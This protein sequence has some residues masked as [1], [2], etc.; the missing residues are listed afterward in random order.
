MVGE[1]P[2]SGIRPEV[3]NMD[4]EE[5]FEIYDGIVVPA[6]ALRQERRREKYGTIPDLPEEE[7]ADPDE[8]ERVVYVEMWWPILRLPQ[9]Y[10][11][12]P[13][14]PTVDDNGVPDWGVFGTADFERY[15]P[16]FSKYRYKAEKMKEQYKDMMIMLRMMSE[17]IPGQAKWE[18]LKQVRKG[19]LDTDGIKDWDTW[20]L[21]VNCVRAWRLERE[22]REVQK[23][24]RKKQQEQMQ[25]LW[26]TG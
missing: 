14:R 8:L 7:L 11:E 4:H 5:Q 9:Q 3:V 12:C 24:G 15:R 18:I 26:G 23:R 10:W 21:A 22:I 25:E 13:I 16:A 20:M 1:P 2:K 19:V 17:R 6:S